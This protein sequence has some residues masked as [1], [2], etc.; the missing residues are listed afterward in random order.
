MSRIF[1]NIHRAQHFRI[2]LATSTG[3]IGVWNS[4]AVH[5]LRSAD[6]VANRPK[7]LSA[8]TEVLAIFFAGDFLY[9]GLALAG[10]LRFLAA[11]LLLGLFMT[12]PR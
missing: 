7:L 5:L 8:V 11:T 6:P 10:L 4:T 2:N 9:A 1:S 12:V 3:Y